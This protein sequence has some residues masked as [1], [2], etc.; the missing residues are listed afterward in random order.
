[1][2]KRTEKDAA[3]YTKYYPWFVLRESFLYF[4]GVIPFSLAAAYMFGALERKTL[5]K[6]IKGGNK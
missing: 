4:S 6:L 1:M 5:D 2:F 3:V